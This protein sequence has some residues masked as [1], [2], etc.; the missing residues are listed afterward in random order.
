M[1]NNIKG[2]DE[3]VGVSENVLWFGRVALMMNSCN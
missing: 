1:L 3:W 2:S